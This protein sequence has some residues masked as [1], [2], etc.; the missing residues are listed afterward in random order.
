VFFDIGVYLSI[1]G[2]AFRK[3]KKIK[4]QKFEKKNQNGYFLFTSI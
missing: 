4:N 2:K 3:S 1:R